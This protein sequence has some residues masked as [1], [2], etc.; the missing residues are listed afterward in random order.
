VVTAFDVFEHFLRPGTAIA[1]V[2]ALVDVHGRLI[3][4]TGDWRTVPDQGE[5]Y[6]SNLFEH[7]IFWTRETFEYVSE[8]YP[9]SIRE[10]SLVNH[11]G[12]RAMGL[13]KRLGLA[14]IARFAPY[15]WFSGAMLAATG[16]DPGHFG[17]PGLV[18]HAFVVLERS[19]AG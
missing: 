6:Y 9:F 8:R 19:E 16:R 5:W 17:A 1:G 7:Q 18:D 11:K 15:S 4:E 12:R 13:A 2:L 14:A 3:V 10:Y